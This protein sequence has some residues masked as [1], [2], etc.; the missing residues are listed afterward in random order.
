LSST[1]TTGAEL[2]FVEIRTGDRAGL[3]AW[4][5]ERLGLTIA[6]DDPAGDFTLLAAG[7]TRLAITGGRDESASGSIALAFR[8]D[9]VEATRARLV[10]HG[11]DASD[12]VDSPEGYRAIDLA[13]PMGHPLQLLQWLPRAARPR[14]DASR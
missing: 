3:A 11:V 6:L 9:E 13:D 4:Y 12:P 5:V 14:G 8:V 7:P 1:P 2:F 10:E